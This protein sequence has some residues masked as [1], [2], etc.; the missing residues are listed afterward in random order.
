MP[1][2]APVLVGFAIIIAALAVVGIHHSSNMF[3]RPLVLGLAHP[4]SFLGRILR[5][6][7][8]VILLNGSTWLL[9]YIQSALSHW[10]HSHLHVLTK[11][12]I[13]HA[14]IAHHTNRELE[15]ISETNA[16]AFDRFHHHVMPQAIARKVTPVKAEAAAAHSLGLKA[17]ARWRAEQK[18]RQR[19]IDR[20]GKRAAAIAA[21]AAAL[22]ALV[23][24]RI[25]PKVRAHDRAIGHSI[26]KRFARDEAWLRRL[27]KAVGI[28][29]LTGLLIKVIARRWPWL[30]CRNWKRIGPQVCRMDPTLLGDLF[31]ALTLVGGTLSLVEFAKEVQAE[32]HIAVDGIR[33]FID[34]TRG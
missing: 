6:T 20:L 9:R 8:L 27:Q 26:P 19:S 5:H 13:G 18:A 21:A 12:F 3:L 29:A 10:A 7:P 15:A 23:H 11:F 24:H 4:R 25:Q 32:T 14:T 17:N 30:F 22:G 1:I 33:A 2:V 16:Y 28:A 31:Q 34:E